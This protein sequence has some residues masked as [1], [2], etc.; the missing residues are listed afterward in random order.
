MIHVTV[1][2]HTCT[3]EGDPSAR[4]RNCDSVSSSLLSLRILSLD[5]IFSFAFLPTPISP[6]SLLFLQCVFTAVFGPAA[7]PCC[8]LPI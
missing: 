1:V 7:P 2:S 8:I 5:S 4:L 6:H 3:P